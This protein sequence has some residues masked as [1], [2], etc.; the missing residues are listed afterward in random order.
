[1]WASAASRSEQAW[2]A[3][4][5][6][7]LRWSR[8]CRRS[9]GKNV[10]LGKPEQFPTDS[11]GNAEPSAGRRRAKLMVPLLPALSRVTWR[12]AIR[13]C[14]VPRYRPNP[15]P[16]LCWAMRPRQYFWSRRGI[17]SAG[18]GSPALLT[19]MLHAAVIERGGLHANRLGLRRM[20]VSIAEQLTQGHAQQAGL[21]LC[22][23]LGAAPPGHPD[24]P[25][26][27]QGRAGHRHDLAHQ[28]RPQ[29]RLP[30]SCR[31]A[32]AFLN[33][34]LPPVGGCG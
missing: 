4:G 12:R 29:C 3:P 8:F 1:M 25:F 2:S 32:S 22:P 7:A 18:R 10:K 11:V 15:A 5:Y 9:R 33:V 31:R 13:R 16:G 20:P 6:T 30:V 14:A 26:A 21:G 17:S 34:S 27:P 24:Q 23:V 19:T 28:Y